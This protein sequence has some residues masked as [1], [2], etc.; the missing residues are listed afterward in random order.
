MSNNQNRDPFGQ[1]Q[2]HVKQG[3]HGRVPPIKV[4]PLNTQQFHSHHI[5]DIQGQRG[6]PDQRFR[7]DSKVTDIP[8]AGLASGNANRANPVSHYSASNVLLGPQGTY[9][10]GERTNQPLSHYNLVEQIHPGHHYEL[11]SSLSPTEHVFPKL[12][13]GD[14]TQQQSSH[15]SLLR[16]FRSV[17]PVKTLALLRDLE[18][19]KP[20][21]E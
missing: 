13:A 15:S 19:L 3:S 4:P 9:G 21:S 8:S 20:R 14:P 17:S 5:A 18:N 12:M 16:P 1:R 10:Y 6:S 11:S 2:S 7:E